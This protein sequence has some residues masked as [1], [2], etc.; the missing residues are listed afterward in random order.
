MTQ[1]QPESMP[2]S[3]L[4]MWGIPD[5]LC[6]HGNP[7]VSQTAFEMSGLDAMGRDLTPTVLVCDGDDTARIDPRVLKDFQ[8]AVLLERTKTGLQALSDLRLPSDLTPEAI[9]KQ[10]DILKE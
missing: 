6:C 7:M 3:M 8:P 10:A 2:S 4:A 9:H 1:S 5:Q